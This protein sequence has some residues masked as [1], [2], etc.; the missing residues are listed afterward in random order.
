[1]EGAAVIHLCKVACLEPHD[2]VLISHPVLGG[3]FVVDGVATLSEVAGEETR[4]TKLKFA[5]NHSR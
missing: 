2:T 4:P 5:F 1:M 3:E